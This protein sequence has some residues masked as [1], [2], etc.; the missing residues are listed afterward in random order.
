METRP[1]SSA[2]FQMEALHPIIVAEEKLSHTEEPKNKHTIGLRT[3]Q[4]PPLQ[5][6]KVDAAIEVLQK[7]I[8]S[9][10]YQPNYPPDVF[11]EKPGLDRTLELEIWTN[12][13]KLGVTESVDEGWDAY[14]YL[15]DAIHQNPAVQEQLFP[16][17]K[18]AHLHRLCRLLA[19]TKPK[20]HRQYLRLLSV[21]TYINYYGGPL[22]QFEFVALIDNAGKG[23]RRVHREDFAYARDVYND[24]MQG[25]LPCVSANLPLEYLTLQGVSF[26]P[27]VYSLSSLASQAA[28]SSDMSAMRGVFKAFETHNITP[29]R[30][31]YLSQLKY[32]IDKQDLPGLRMGLRMMRSLNMEIGIDG[33]N[34]CMDGYSRLGRL[35]V[36]LMIYRLL[37]HNLS[38][39]AWEYGDEMEIDNMI[40][41]LGEEYIFFE[42]DIVPN[43]TTYR[44]AIKAMAYHGHFHLAVETL[45]EMANDPNS[46]VQEPGLEEYRSLFLGFRKH[47]VPP[48]MHGDSGWT[49]ANLREIFKRFLELP[50][51]TQ[52]NHFT[53]H[54]IM[55]AFD[56]CTDND[57]AELRI[58]WRHIHQAFA[59]TP[60]K[61]KSRSTTALL[62]KRLFPDER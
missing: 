61:P 43:R 34:H 47:A 46:A 8:E 20:T 13:K 49:L 57:V 3:R 16:H 59:V 12:L 53:L 11:W 21:M 31:T 23:L 27:S 4:V 51:T 33:L 1:V 19:E 38:P 40:A 7:R 26:K 39:E 32:F 24:L 55:T 9:P 60:I 42:A 25:R 30:I 22:Q 56:K 28:R 62:K 58:I 54:I 44:T 15:V 17:I 10:T 14:L 5:Y 37:R 29:N 45:L 52:I 41:K 2:R 50:S 36:S 48:G 6:A 35:D 18:F